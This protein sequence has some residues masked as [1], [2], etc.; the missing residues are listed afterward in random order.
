[1]RRKKKKLQD[2]LNSLFSS[3]KGLDQEKD[4]KIGDK[5]AAL[6]PSEEIT[7][8]KDEEIADPS[9]TSGQ[10][11]SKEE[12]SK[13]VKQQEDTIEPKEVLEAKADEES[14][15]DEAISEVPQA[16]DEPED[17]PGGKEDV[18]K[19]VSTAIINDTEDKVIVP[20]DL[21][22]DE[23]RE[24]LIFS[25][26]DVSYSVIVGRV[27]TIIKP[28]TVYPVPGTE[29]YITGLI[30][31]RGEVV[32]VLNLRTRFGLDAREID[33]NT[34]FVVIEYG[35]YLLSLIVDAVEGIEVIPESLFY[36][37]SGIV[38]NIDTNY[39]SDIARFEG[40]LILV[41]NLTELIIHAET[42]VEM[43]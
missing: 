26:G 40:R 11:I 3:Q 10:D 12:A 9:I 15:V 38:T 1:M 32:P 41:L 37:P 19:S 25:L 2:N 33:G 27:R 13:M 42:K 7:A 22:E 8:S 43:G 4:E 21:E 35:E 39:L 18:I 34:R 36:T 30:N 29:E 17:E 28:Q 24:I 23:T 16:P 14:P 6:D 5:T 20:I 31:L